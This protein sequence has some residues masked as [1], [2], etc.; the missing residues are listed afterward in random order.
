[1]ASR[2][3]STVRKAEPTRARTGSVVLDFLVQEIP[4]KRINKKTENLI[5]GFRRL[6]YMIFPGYPGNYEFR[7]A[8]ED[9]PAICSPGVAGSRT[10]SG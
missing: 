4:A 8:P 9:F 3:S 2:A 7:N 6:H 5:T 1:M 10:I